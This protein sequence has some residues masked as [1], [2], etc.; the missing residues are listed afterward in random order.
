M[1]NSNYLFLA[2]SRI[3]INPRET[4]KHNSSILTFYSNASCL[5]KWGKLEAFNTNSIINKTWG[6]APIRWSLPKKALLRKSCPN[7]FSWDTSNANKFHFW[8]NVRRINVREIL[9]HNFRFMWVFVVCFNLHISKFAWPFFYACQ[10][11]FVW[12]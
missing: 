5:C 4:Q 12:L 1:T 2:N 3:S 10:I 9:R 11:R 6:K 7:E 8:F